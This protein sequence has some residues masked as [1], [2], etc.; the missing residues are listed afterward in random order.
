MPSADRYAKYRADQTT[1]WISKTAQDFLNRERT[2][3]EGTAGVLDREIGEL[4]KHRRANPSIAPEPRAAVGASAVAAAAGRN[5]LR[6][7]L[8]ASLS[9]TRRLPLSRLPRFE[10][11]SRTPPQGPVATRAPARRAPVARAPRARRLLSG[12]LL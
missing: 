11:A 4:K 3:G 8:R 7:T 10:R 2:G 1:V 5:R 12:F 9:P 6:P